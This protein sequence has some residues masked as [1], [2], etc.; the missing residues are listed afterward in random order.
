MPILLPETLLPLP[1]QEFQKLDYEIMAI[2]FEVHNQLGRLYDE[3]IYQNELRE[4]CIRKG[5][6]TAD[7]YEIQLL[8]KDYKKPLYI[9]LLIENCVYELKTI[10][11]IREP[12]RMQTLNYLFATNTRHGKIINFRPASVEH[13]FVSTT[14]D[15]VARKQFSIQTKTWTPSSK[16]AEQLGQLMMELLD[17]WGAFFDSHLYEEALVYLLG[18]NERVE[19]AVNIKNET[20]V[21]GKQK[22]NTLSDTEFFIITSARNHFQ[23]HKSLL[24]RLLNH[25]PFKNLYWINLN[26]SEIEFSTLSK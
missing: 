20:R 13:E 18:G 12:H 10:Q 6:K 21:L 17:D 15:H 23:Q 25:T 9:D 2:A 14:L 8:H 11:A 3:Q 24:K 26:H 22:L 5:L 1:E 16:R 19:Q 7:E 4:Q